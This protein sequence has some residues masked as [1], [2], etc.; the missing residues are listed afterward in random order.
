MKHLMMMI[1]VQDAYEQFYSH[2]NVS[3]GVKSLWT[4]LDSGLVQKIFAMGS[5]AEV[6]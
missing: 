5:P 2:S 4:T 3:S 6:S 1:R